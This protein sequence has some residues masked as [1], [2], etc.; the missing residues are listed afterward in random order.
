MKNTAKLSLLLLLGAAQQ[1]L[2]AKKSL[3]KDA[4]IELEK[5]RVIY[6]GSKKGECCDRLGLP[7]IALAWGSQS[8]VKDVTEAQL[9]KAKDEL[10][11]QEKRVQELEKKR[12]DYLIS[13]YPA[14]AEE[15]KIQKVLNEFRQDNK[16]KLSLAYQDDMEVHEI[17]TAENKAQAAFWTYW[18]LQNQYDEEH[19]QF[20]PANHR[21]YSPEK[22]LTPTDMQK[23]AR[24]A[25]TINLAPGKSL[26]L[27]TL[28]IGSSTPSP[29]RVINYTLALPDG[30]EVSGNTATLKTKTITP[31]RK[32]GDAPIVGAPTT[33][34]FMV[35]SPRHAAPATFYILEHKQMGDISV[36]ATVRITKGEDSVM[37]GPKKATT[38]KPTKPVKAAARRETLPVPLVPVKVKHTSGKKAAPTSTPVVKK[39]Q[40]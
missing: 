40:K 25:E 13:K 31:I 2:E 18:Q 24:N 4:K 23:L 12:N 37:P 14:Y 7:Q 8:A 20:L 10:K 16:E 27:P 3:S 29:K 30:K 36:F 1:G 6:H 15:Q 32:K 34:E 17:Y 5:K 38:S 33:Y 22:A 9:N 21:P 26:N 19:Q 28:Y 39:M 35:S 11:I